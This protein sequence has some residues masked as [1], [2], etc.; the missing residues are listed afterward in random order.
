MSRVDE[1]QAKLT[2]TVSDKR[3]LQRAVIAAANTE[4]EL[5]EE[6][7]S[8][9]AMKAKSDEP[10]E[11]SVVITQD[12]DI[13]PRGYGGDCITVIEKKPIVI[14]DELSQ[15]MI[16]AGRGFVITTGWWVR[17][18]KAAGIDATAEARAGDD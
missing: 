3:T 4:A 2:E 6:L 9:E 15:K 17:A 18:L 12:G 7:A 16:N 1:I 13:A 14:T 5:R 10:R 8:L 11:W